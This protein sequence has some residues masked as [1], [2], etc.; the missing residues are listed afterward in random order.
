[1]SLDELYE[2]KPWLKSKMSLADRERIK[3]LFAAGNIVEVLLV[4]G[5]SA[6]RAMSSDTRM[7]VTHGVLG[8]DSL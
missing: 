3:A 7:K 2:D 1:M 5:I 8:P 6:F 4:N